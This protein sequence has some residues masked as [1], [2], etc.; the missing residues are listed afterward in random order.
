ML[1]SYPVAC[2]HDH[3]DWTGK[4]V[5]SHIQGG[6]NAEI[7]IMHRAW[8]RCPRCKC[9]WEVRITEDKVTVAPVVHEDGPAPILTEVP[10][11]TGPPVREKS[12]AQRKDPLRDDGGEA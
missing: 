12:L 6:A 11:E 4:V 7:I 10:P 9:D 5:P 1:T 2:P 8:F 3:C